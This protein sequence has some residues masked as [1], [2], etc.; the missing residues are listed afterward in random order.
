MAADKFESWAIVELM[1]HVKMGGRVTEEE[2]FGVKMGRIDIPQADGGFVTQ[3]FGGGSVYRLTPTDEATARR[4]A[5]LGVPAPVHVWQLPPPEKAA[6]AG[7]KAPETE[8]DVPHFPCPEEELQTRG[9][10]QDDDLPY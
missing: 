10:S 4:V 6:A 1:G 3:Y 2:R 9:G 7:D 5:T 8:D